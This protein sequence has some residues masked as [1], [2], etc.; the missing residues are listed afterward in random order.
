MKALRFY[1][2][3]V[4]QLTLFSLLDFFSLEE[5]IANVLKGVWAQEKL[6]KVMQATAIKPW[7]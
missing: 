6:D 5:R 3:Q 2:V 7:Q 1:P 4:L